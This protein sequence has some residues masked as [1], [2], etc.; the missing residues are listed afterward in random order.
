M[1]PLL[2]YTS[3]ILT[4]SHK[5]LS[6]KPQ[7]DPVIEISKDILFESFVNRITLTAE[8]TVRVQLNLPAQPSCLGLFLRHPGGLT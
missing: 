7:M 8:A 2:Y 4:D 6:E 1:L 3:P 5:L